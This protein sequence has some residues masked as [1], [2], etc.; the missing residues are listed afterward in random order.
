MFKSNKKTVSDY[1]SIGYNVSENM[2]TKSLENFLNSLPFKTKIIDISYFGSA[3]SSVR[4]V[5]KVEV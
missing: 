2:D 1:T 3:G 5:Y 4:V